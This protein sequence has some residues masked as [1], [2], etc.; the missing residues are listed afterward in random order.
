M[1]TIIIMGYILF[2]TVIGFMM[3]RS[4]EKVKRMKK[5]IE[6]IKELK[7]LIVGPKEYEKLSDEE[8]MKE[9]EKALK[10]SGILEL[11]MKEIQ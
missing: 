2:C 7:K 10:L 3:G 4:Y 11:L 6:T 1:Y 8:K 5:N 9:M